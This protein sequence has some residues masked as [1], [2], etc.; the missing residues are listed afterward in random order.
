MGFIVSSGKSDENV[1]QNILYNIN[2][3]GGKGLAKLLRIVQE[4]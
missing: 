4:K 3:N 1:I 2:N